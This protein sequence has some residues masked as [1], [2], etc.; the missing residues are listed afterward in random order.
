[1]VLYIRHLL[2]LILL[3]SQTIISQEKLNPSATKTL[4]VLELMNPNNSPYANKTVRFIDENKNEIKSTT[5]SRG[6]LKV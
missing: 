5:N 3:I 2:L 4:L 1:M 6:E